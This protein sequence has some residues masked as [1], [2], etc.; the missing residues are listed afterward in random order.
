MERGQVSQEL[1]MGEAH[2]SF[3]RIYLYHMFDLCLVI[4]DHLVLN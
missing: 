3:A 2:H 1:R 4:I